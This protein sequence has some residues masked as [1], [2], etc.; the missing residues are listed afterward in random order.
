MTGFKYL[1][2]RFQKATGSEN[3]PITVLLTVVA[4]E[5]KYHT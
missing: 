3:M 5:R 2:S 1:E 4:D